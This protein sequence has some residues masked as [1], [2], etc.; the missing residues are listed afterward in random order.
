MAFA[1]APGIPQLA[2]QS[3]GYLVAAMEQYAA[4][5]RPHAVL[6]DMTPRLSEAEIRD[7]AA[8]YAGLPA[9]ARMASISASVSSE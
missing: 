2:Q 1:A 3:A 9:L 8:Y 4:G 7:V 6:K 5:K